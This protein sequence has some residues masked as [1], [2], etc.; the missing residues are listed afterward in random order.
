[1][2]YLRRTIRPTKINIHD[3]RQYYSYLNEVFPFKSIQI[4][5]TLLQ[6][7]GSVHVLFNLYKSFCPLFNCEMK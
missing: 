7:S 4:K 3:Y 1:M 6:L 2:Y 5:L